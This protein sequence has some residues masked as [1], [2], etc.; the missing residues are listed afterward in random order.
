MTWPAAALVAEGALSAALALVGAYISFLAVLL[1]AAMYRARLLRLRRAVSG[2]IRP[3]LDSALVA[4]LAGG[5][6]ISVFRQY[7]AS[8][9]ADIAESILRFQTTV[10]GS[11]RDRLCGLALS[12]GLVEAWCR[13]SRSRNV[14]RRRTAFANLAFACVFE[15]CRRVAGDLLLDALKD[16]DEEVRL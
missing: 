7:I 14:I 13:Q 2:K 16:C 12:L 4:F 10:V 11:A 1:L 9:P 8:H 5:T 15:P 6:D 3:T